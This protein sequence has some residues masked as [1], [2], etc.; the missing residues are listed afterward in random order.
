MFVSHA[1]VYFHLSLRALSP[2]ITVTANSELSQMSPGNDIAQVTESINTKLDS[3]NA[4]I[5]ANT[6]TSSAIRMELL[7]EDRGDLAAAMSASQSVVNGIKTLED[8]YKADLHISTAVEVSAEAQQTG[9]DAKA[10]D[11]KN[12]AY[13]V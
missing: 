1:L 5:A 4:A 6:T 11:V 8:S 9:V 3:W 2:D 10:A 13:R 12:S 7:Q